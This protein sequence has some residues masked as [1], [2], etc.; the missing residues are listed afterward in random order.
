MDNRDNPTLR[1][2]PDSE[3]SGQGP[4]AMNGICRILDRHYGAIFDPSDDTWTAVKVCRAGNQTDIEGGF[5]TEE[6]A[7][8]RAGAE[9]QN[10]LRDN[11][12]FGVGA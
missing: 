2:E 3:V 11:S 10:D 6:E 7:E 1:S 12:Q 8:E 9:H 4:R 5:A